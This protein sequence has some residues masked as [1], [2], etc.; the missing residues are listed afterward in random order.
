MLSAIQQAWAVNPALLSAGC[1]VCAGGISPAGTRQRVHSYLWIL[2]PELSL[3]PVPTC[4]LQR[5]LSQSAEKAEPP[6][7]VQR[8]E[9]RAHSHGLSLLPVPEAK[10]LA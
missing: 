8:S 6:L 10:I 5:G 7:G 3:G 1:V 4:P 9:P 2:R